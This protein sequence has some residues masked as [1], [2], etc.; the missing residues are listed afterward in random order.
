MRGAGFLADR[1][2]ARPRGCPAW[3]SR[4][5]F[6]LLDP[7]QVA[8]PAGRLRAPAARPRGAAAARAPAPLPR[9]RG[10]GRLARAGAGRLHA[11]VHRAQ[12]DARRA[13][14]SIDDR[15][16]T[17]ADITLPDPLLR[18]RG[19]RDR[20]RRRRCARSAAPRRAP[21]STRS[22]AR[23]ALRPRR[24][25]AGARRHVADRRRL[26]ALARR[27]RASCRESVEPT[28]RRRATPGARHARPASATASSSR[29]GVGARRRALGASSRRDAHR[30]RGARASAARRPRSCRGSRASSRSSRARASRSGCCSTSRP[31]RAPTTS[32][33]LFEDR[34]HTR[35]AGQGPHRQRRPRPALARRAPGRARRRADGHAAERAGGRRGAQPPRRGRGA[36]APR[37]QTS[38]ARPQLGAGRRGS[39]P[40]PSTSS[41]GR[42]ARGRQVSCSAAAARRAT[43]APGSSTWSASTPTRSTLPAWYRPN[44]GR[45][46]DLAF[47]LFTGEGER[48]RLNRI[49]NRRWALSA[50]GTASSAAL[51]PADTVY[52]VTPLHHPSGLLMSIG[53]AVAGGARIALAPRVRP[54]RRSGTRC[55]ATASPSPPTPGRCCATSSTPRRSPGERHHPLR[56]FIGSGMPRGAVAA[57]RRAL[58][59]RAGARVLRLDR[60]RGDPRQPQ[61]R[62]SPARW[63][64][65]C[66]AAPRCGSPRYD[67]DAGRLTHGPDGFARAL[68][69]RR[70]RACCSRGRAGGAATGDTPLRGVF[71]RDDAWLV[72]RRPVP[73]RRRRRLL[74]GRPAPRARPTADGPVA[75]AADPRR[76]RATSTASTWRSPTASPAGG[77]EPSCWWRAVTLRDGRDARAAAR[78]T[79]V[80]ALPPRPSARPSCTSSTR[81][82]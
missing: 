63:A 23:R 19:R 66:P 74:A 26:G 5:G 39:S 60:G 58:R 78:L 9:G 12:P 33:F 13:A 36:H 14:S 32:C 38:R 48:T 16:V 30:A 15:L 35:G 18:R 53:G 75:L 50:F 43:S 6:R 76:A 11:P 62:A 3:A 1:V 24:R 41:R 45:A 71:A 20:A 51:T 64:A 55:A 77:D 40:T 73:P 46:R 7:G 44:P 22:A 59:A 61:R 67:L 17:L 54:G 8:A 21:R 34:A 31:Q 69:A 81:S 57:G 49:T 82:P 68:R 72:D 47:V 10:L 79:A 4:T 42:E 80:R 28:R 29:R 56:L 52:S 37:R 2:L 25:L 65:R 27:R 70:A